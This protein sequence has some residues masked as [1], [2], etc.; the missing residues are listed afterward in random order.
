MVFASLKLQNCVF[1]QAPKGGVET[2]GGTLAKW[3]SK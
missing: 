1:I 3:V 2:V